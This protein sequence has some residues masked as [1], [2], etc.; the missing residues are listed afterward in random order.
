MKNPAGRKILSAPGVIEKGL[1]ELDRLNEVGADL[2]GAFGGKGRAD[3]IKLIAQ[4]ADD[5][6]EIGAGVQIDPLG[7]PEVGR[8]GHCQCNPA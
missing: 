6:L 7:M 5:A 3:G 4:P 1:F 2:T 8:P